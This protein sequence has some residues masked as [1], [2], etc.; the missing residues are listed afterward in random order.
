MSELDILIEALN[1]SPDNN[2]LRK[3]V[4]KMQFNIGSYEEAYDNYRL[5][6][7]N[8]KD[9]LEILESMIQ[10]MLR[11]E[12]YDG[13][14]KLVENKINEDW[15]FGML[16]LSKCLF[17]YEEY[18]DA[19]K[20]Y[21]KAVDIMPGL[22]DDDYYKELLKH[23]TSQKVRLK[24]IN[25][26]DNKID[27]DEDDDFVRPQTTF[28]DVGGMK[29]VKESIKINIIYPLK[30]N[31]I[32]KAYGKKAGGG[33]LLYGPPG[34]GK[35]FIAKA[36]AG[37]CEASFTDIAITDILNMYIGESEKNLHS[38]FETA[39]RKKPSIIFIDEIDA[40][41]GKR[42]ASYNSAGRSITNQLLMEMD[43]T[44]NNN[45][46]MLIIGATNTPWSVDSALKRPGRFDRILL[47]PP[48]DFEARIEIIKLNLKDK[49]CI[50]IDY[51]T[52][53]KKMKQYSGA[54]IK[55]VCDAASE[56]VIKVAIEKGEIIP[57]KTSDILNALKV[58][59]PS[60]LEWLN[61]AKNYATYS[62]Q[63]GIYDEILEYLK[64]DA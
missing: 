15:P 54:D 9:D 46:K 55:A 27:D 16:A 56:A 39:R 52:I 38:I 12:N 13:V 42:Q 63:S 5:L 36:T 59:K 30:N 33:I 53:S 43:S 45:E 18:D 47:V 2:I 62:N 3:Q 32:F 57:I 64:T 17:Y 6:Y 41:G 19:M 10:C 37:E 4:A 48:P 35:T 44:Q 29:N 60:T 31:K 24:V 40:I 28:K 58:I 20:N 7:K 22:E 61:T 50:K 49:P 34:C 8:K 23:T 14:N 21:E 25:F 51:E 1:I 11:L 26:R